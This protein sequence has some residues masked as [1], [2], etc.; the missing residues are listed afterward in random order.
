MHGKVRARPA[1][2]DPLTTPPVCRTYDG[3]P[4]IRFQVF[5]SLEIKMHH[6]SLVLPA[7]LLGVAI[8]ERSRVSL[9]IVITMNP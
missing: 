3:F 8:G 5:S 9:C 2:V 1:T 4:L 7:L 6:L